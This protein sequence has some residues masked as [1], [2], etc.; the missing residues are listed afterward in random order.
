MKIQDIRLPPRRRGPPDGGRD[1]N[2]PDPDSNL[3]ILI[4]LNPHHYRES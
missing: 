1:E 3:H 2:S 4:D